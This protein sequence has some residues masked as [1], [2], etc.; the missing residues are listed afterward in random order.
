MKS[1]FHQTDISPY[2]ASVHTFGCTE[3]LWWDGLC[4]CSSV[5][6]HDYV[7]HMHICTLLQ[8]L[9][10]CSMVGWKITEVDRW[11]TFRAEQ[12]HL[13]PVRAL[14]S[15]DLEKDLPWG[16]FFVYRNCWD[17]SSYTFWLCMQ[18]CWVYIQSTWTWMSWQCWSLSD[19]FGL[20]FFREVWLYNMHLELKKIDFLCINFIRGPST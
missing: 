12:L 14:H 9:L 16:Y 8:C 20:I 4:P 18:L 3:A 10:W 17:P 5:D 1:N 15:W 6:P 7:I 19:F 11:N 13:T 2:S